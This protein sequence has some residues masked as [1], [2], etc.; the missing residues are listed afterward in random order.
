MIDYLP[1]E[2][3][4]RVFDYLKFKI[5]N[6]SQIIS[7]KWRDHVLGYE[8]HHCLKN[9]KNSD[10]SWQAL[11]I[12]ISNK[13]MDRDVLNALILLCETL[14]KSPPL[15]KVP[16]E[17]L[18]PLSKRSTHVDI[19]SYLLNH[20]AG[21]SITC[22]EVWQY[23]LMGLKKSQPTIVRVLANHLVENGP[24]YS[25]IISY[26]GLGKFLTQNQDHVDEMMTSL[27]FLYP[28]QQHK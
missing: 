20:S 19:T 24:V 12:A 6:D 14:P 8:I 2:V 4:F 22:D 25:E 3:C 18:G 17:C 23:L 11:Q 10:N 15:S 5:L 13:W 16:S 21:V 27:L 26:S 28:D 1:T 9:S 7:K